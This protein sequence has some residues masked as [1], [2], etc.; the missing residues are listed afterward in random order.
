ML[1]LSLI[2]Y[3]ALILSPFVLPQLMS[4]ATTPTLAS[5]NIFAPQFVPTVVLANTSALHV[6]PT[7]AP[8]ITTLC[9][10]NL[11][12]SPLFHNDNDFTPLHH[13]SVSYDDNWR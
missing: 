1:S 11:A 2:D 12:A 6:A 7:V 4:H 8:A 10:Y 9:S 13:Y 3:H 5:V